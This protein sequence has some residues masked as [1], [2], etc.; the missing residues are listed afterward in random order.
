MITLFLKFKDEAESLPHL[1]TVIPEVKN[2]SGEVIRQMQL[3]P[4]YK[5][6]DIVGVVRKPTGNMKT[7]YFSEDEFCQAPELAPIDGWHIN[8][9]VTNEDTSD[10]D[11]FKVQV[12]N[13]VRVFA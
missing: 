12:T 13:P 8:L 5:C 6:M 3:L 11:P 9:R 10:L 7:Y 1:Y 4:K 2:E